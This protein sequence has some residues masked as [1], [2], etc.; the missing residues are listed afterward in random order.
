M[1]ESARQGVACQ[2][3]TLPRARAVRAFAGGP[4]RVEF[5]SIRAIQ[6]PAPL[7]HDRR[8]VEADVGSRD[9]VELWRGLENTA[10]AVFQHDA[11]PQESSPHRPGLDDT[12]FKELTAHHRAPSR[13]CKSRSRVLAPGAS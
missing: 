12:G 11:E 9:A 1:R 5:N 2:G 13:I 3:D 6:I 8:A 4:R 10:L 7:F